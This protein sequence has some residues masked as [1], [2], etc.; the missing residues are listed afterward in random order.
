MDFKISL[1]SPLLFRCLLA[2]ICVVI[3]HV[4]IVLSPFEKFLERGRVSSSPRLIDTYKGLKLYEYMGHYYGLDSLENPEVIRQINTISKYSWA[5]HSNIDKLKSYVDRNADLLIRS[6]KIVSAFKGFLVSSS[7]NPPIP[8]TP[9]SPIWI[10]QSPPKYPEWL[11]FNFLQPVVIKVLGI[12]SHA[13]SVKEYV[14]YH[15][16][17]FVFQGSMDG[18]V[19]TDLMRTENNVYNEQYQWHEWAINNDKA[20]LYYRIYITAGNADYLSVFEVRVA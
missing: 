1:G 15:P 4:S 16:Q 11:V 20:F 19:W 8:Q 9:N 7:I 17:D 6:N 3:L 10:A 12:R 13:E 18:S 5:A 14:N 2:S